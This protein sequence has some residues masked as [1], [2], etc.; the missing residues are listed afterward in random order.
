[1]KKRAEQGSMQL[2]GEVQELALEDFLK[3]Q[4]P[5]DQIDDVPKGVKGADVIQTVVNSLQQ[6]C[7]KI[8][9]ESKRTKNFKDDWID[10]LKYDQKGQQGRNSGDCN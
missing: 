2:Q 4:F 9:Y 10:K 1:M 7:G 5:F 6:N 3:Y 8:I